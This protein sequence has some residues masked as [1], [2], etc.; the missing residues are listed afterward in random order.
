MTSL[1][2]RRDHDNNSASHPPPARRTQTEPTVVQIESTVPQAKCGNMMSFRG[3]LATL[4]LSSLA[5]AI[6]LIWTY[7]EIDYSDDTSRGLTIGVSGVAATLLGMTRSSITMFNVVLF[8]HIGIEVGVLDTAITFANQDGVSDVDMGLAITA[9]IIIILHLIP[10]LLS[11]NFMALAILG[12]AGLVINTATTVFLD[13][14]STLLASTS[15]AVLL[16]MIYMTSCSQTSMLTSLQNAL[17]AG[18]CIVC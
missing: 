17:V 10:F 18:D 6:P 7:G 1:G 11:D 9:A 5:L 14:A 15:A 16:I 4:L 8:F 2:Y 3:F 12:S 13:A